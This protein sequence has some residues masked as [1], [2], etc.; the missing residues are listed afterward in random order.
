M[1]QTKVGISESPATPSRHLGVARGQRR[2][3][4][5]R[6]KKP[7]TRLEIST[8]ENSARG[9]MKANNS[10]GFLH[11]M[12]SLVSRFWNTSLKSANSASGMDAAFAKA[13]AAAAAES[14]AKPTTESRVSATCQSV[15]QEKPADLYG[16]A[17]GD[18]SVIGSRHAATI[19]EHSRVRRPTAE[20]VFSPSPFAYNKKLAA[21]TSSVASLRDV[22]RPRDQLPA[23]SRRHSVGRIDVRRS[24][25]SDAGSP[26]VSDYSSG[27]SVSESTGCISPSN[28]RRLLS[29]L[30]AI[31]TPVRDARSH[32][33]DGMSVGQSGQSSSS[34]SV[35]YSPMP[36]RRLPVSLLALSDTPSR[37]HR[38][39][40]ANS[41]DVLDK[42][43]LRRSAS[44]KTIPR[45]HKTAPSLARTIQLQQARKA[46]ASR[47]LK[48][49][50]AVEN[51]EHTKAYT[52]ASLAG[53]VH[54]RDENED[55]AYSRRKSK[56]R[57]AT[58]GHVV[59]IDGDMSH[60]EEA[61]NESDEEHGRRASRSSRRR[62]K[63][64]R[65]DS[66]SDRMAV[67]RNVKWQFSARL[68]AVSDND[69]DLSSSESDEDRDALAAKVPVGKIR[70]GELIGLSM[71][72]TASASASSVT[73]SAAVVRSTG[74]G[75][76]RT[77]V[78]LI[79]EPEKPLSSLAATPA[80]SAT[81][82]TPPR[83]SAAPLISFSTPVPVV[84]AAP[85][86]ASAAASAAASENKEAPATKPGL[87]GS[88]AVAKPSQDDDKDGASGS[89]PAES[90]ASKPA[91][92]S[93][94][95]PTSTTTTTTTAAASA[96]AAQTSGAES[97]SMPA[98]T[99]SFFKPAGPSSVESN[100]RKPSAEE[101]EKPA[102]AI[103]ASSLFGS[104]KP[105][106]A[107]NNESADK[108][109]TPVKR[110]TLF[111]ASQ[112]A[113][114]SKD[115]AEG[116]A[117][118]PAPIQFGFGK[119]AASEDAKASEPAPSL[120]SFGKS[121]AETST[122]ATIVA[123]AFAPAAFAA[124]AAEAQET[125]KTA[126]S[127]FSSAF[128]KP[129]ASTTGDSSG[130]ASKPASGSVSFGSTLAAPAA[131]SKSSDQAKP[132]PLFSFGAAGG[133]TTGAASSLFGAPK[134]S[135]GAA[136]SAA[137]ENKQ[138]AF[139]S[140]AAPASSTAAPQTD[141]PAMSFAS[142]GGLGG[143][144]GF[145][146][147]GE[148]AGAKTVLGQSAA[149]PA[150]PVPA[151]AAAASLFAP[152]AATDSSKPSFSLGSLASSA[153]VAAPTKT[154]D[155]TTTSA[156][157][158]GTT[159]KPPIFSFSAG[160]PQTSNNK[161]APFNISTKTSAPSGNEPLAKR[162]HF[163]LNPSLNTP[164]AAS[165]ESTTVPTPAVPTFSS[166]AAPTF[167]GAPAHTPSSLSFA[168]A[169]SP[170][171]TPAT[172]GFSFNKPALPT[173]TSV[174]GPASSFGGASAT[175]SF[176]GAGPQSSFSFGSGGGSGSSSGFG[177]QQPQQQQS[178]GFGQQSNVST[179]GAFGQP[180]AAS[181]SAFGQQPN[182][183]ASAFGQ[184]SSASVG[185]GQ[186]SN[187]S[188]GFGV[189]PNTA[190]TS[191]FGQQSNA[192][193]GFG[194]QPSTAS[195][196][197]FG[198]Q[199]N[200]SAGFGQPN[201]ASTTGFGQ[202]SSA[203]VGFGQQQQQQQGMSSNGFGSG[204]GNGFG[205]SSN[206]STFGA[207]P[208]TAPTTG[209]TP[210]FNFTQ[211]SNVSTSGGGSFQFGAGGG[212]SGSRV[213]SGSGGA[214]GTPFAFGSNTSQQGTPGGP[215]QFSGGVAQQSNPGGMSMGRV[216]G[217]SN[218]STNSQ[219]RRIARPR[220]R[221]PH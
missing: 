191:A 98:P 183:S 113:E 87:F 155:L 40:L 54:M 151:T 129:A 5:S 196:S 45:S 65:R 142:S 134:A 176:G 12:R 95:N 139:G 141:A 215:F 198:Q 131:D 72:P 89:K 52:V 17:D 199:S 185:F 152:A 29:T 153:S 130:A 73:G 109:K 135:T 25:L 194:I 58:D 41:I 32:T 27:A 148:S 16:N 204:F 78:P 160:T 219:G 33:A 211:G 197:A 200:A 161:P 132:T 22:A 91:L 55:Y 104:F 188:T 63:K 74:F 59:A 193:T 156:S 82:S 6:S 181:T 137:T 47:L 179:P 216:T 170:A 187:A 184:Q 195:T 77:P 147:A 57:R 100:K 24:R 102:A 76:T 18:A 11:G 105:T 93:L 127:G 38:S 124:P 145:K 9:E 125:H 53:E 174:G 157:A 3:P 86:A 42:Q 50:A 2:T 106:T 182:A 99:F 169:S 210:Q 217:G 108:P 208:S 15:V 4:A 118:K 92:F 143:F 146:P 10:P 60:G 61:E 214:P 140:F 168:H 121:Q 90:A 107:S 207:A 46:V 221:R 159:A 79:S 14:S 120:F 158:S 85:L 56:R 138:P 192:S 83:A 48:T 123:P 96:V 88:F 172:P 112:P 119:A 175:T 171:A 122:A 80:T 115:T 220:T 13:A 103:A 190:S 94:G 167:G 36:L 67:D 68:D 166:T 202:Q 8:N 66:R 128:G 1:V 7:Y 20:S 71:R 81:P 49:K 205:A 165:F 180:N 186:Q 173:N 101:E 206:A 28:A 35:Q 97:E 126:D 37:T 23:L 51:V 43:S 162:P 136:D 34:S 30:N 201:T 26:T 150:A 177:Q 84:T 110:A 213:V 19:A 203:S 209:N 117:S 163:M 218:V 114:A 164:S 64:S 189:Q 39:P 133:A 21:A 144:G 116:E 69:D 75:S 31:S 178:S 111:S 70:G 212:G 44:L 154:F 149:A 62:Q